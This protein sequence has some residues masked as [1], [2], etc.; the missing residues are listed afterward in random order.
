[1]AAKGA[2]SRLGSDTGDESKARKGSTSGTGKEEV[3]CPDCSKVVSKSDAGIQC[4]VCEDWF[5]PKCQKITDDVYWGPIYK[6]SYARLMTAWHLRRTYA[7]LVN[8][9]RLTKNHKLN[10]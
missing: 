6:E 7:E 1:M 4:E 5:H 8:C 10:L 9:E 3:K 2:R